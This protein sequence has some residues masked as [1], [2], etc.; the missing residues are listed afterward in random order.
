MAS[1]KERRRLGRAVDRGRPH[2][3]QLHGEVGL[4]AAFLSQV[5]ADASSDDALL[6][7]EARHFLQDH[8]AVRMWCSLGGL[9]DAAFHEHVQRAL[10]PG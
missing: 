3:R 8:M 2:G 10:G 1:R 7:T 4:V 5:L 6:R 9:D